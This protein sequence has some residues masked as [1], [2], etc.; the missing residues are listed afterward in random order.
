MLEMAIL[1]VWA[2]WGYA[3]DRTIQLNVPACDSWGSR[4]RIGAILKKTEGVI[5]YEIPKDVQTE[6]AWTSAGRGHR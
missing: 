6:E 5:R 4:A 2:P 3:A 1:M